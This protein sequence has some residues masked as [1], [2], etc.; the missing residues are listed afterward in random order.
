MSVCRTNPI[1]SLSVV[2]GGAY[3]GMREK[4]QRRGVRGGRGGVGEDLVRLG[5]GTEY[6]CRKAAEAKEAD[7]KGR[8]AAIIIAPIFI[9]TITTTVAII[10]K[11]INL[12]INRQFY[13]ERRGGER[14]RPATKGLLERLRVSRSPNYSPA[15]SLTH[16]LTRPLTH[17]LLAQGGGTEIPSTAAR[18][19]GCWAVD[20]A[21][22][23]WLSMH[24]Y[25]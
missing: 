18:L 22:P 11:M 19:P 1:S 23:G 21:L 14:K 24:Q 25:H 17:L 15:C 10:I 4:Q 16:P 8:I 12:V 5:E 9:T 6:A 13:C 7:A 3:E 2:R 20:I